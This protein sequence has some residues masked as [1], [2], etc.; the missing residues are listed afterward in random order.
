[1]ERADF[2]KV[3][4]A[5]KGI[6]KSGGSRVVYIRRNERFPVLNYHIAPRVP[7]SWAEKDLK[8]DPPPDGARRFKDLTFS[9]GSWSAAFG[10]LRSEAILVAHD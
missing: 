1:M 8:L 4:V 3:R 6:G 2:R 7:P 5:R 10:K 9:V